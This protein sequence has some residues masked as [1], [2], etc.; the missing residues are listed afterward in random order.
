MPIPVT[1]I[2]KESSKQDGDCSS[3]DDTVRPKGSKIIK[4]Q[5]YDKN[6]KHDTDEEKPKTC[7]KNTD[8]KSCDSN[9]KISDKVD[10]Q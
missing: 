6:K 5:P 4:L 7:P 9:K 1:E 8:E 2:T 3:Q 10:Q